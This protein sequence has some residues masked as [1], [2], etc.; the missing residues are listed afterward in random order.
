MVV[1]ST[2]PRA[3]IAAKELSNELAVPLYSQKNLQERDFGD[4]NK[5]EW[6]QIS[7]KLKKLT[8]EDRY[9]FKPPNGESWQEMELRLREALKDIAALK[10]DVVAVMTH[11]G[12]IRVIHAIL[13]NMTN[14]E[15]TKFIPVLGESFVMEFEPESID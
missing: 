13:G 8:L 7:L 14:E 9:S 2:L 3:A 6:P 1:T 4:W 12:C 10:K 5:E 15:T 11:A